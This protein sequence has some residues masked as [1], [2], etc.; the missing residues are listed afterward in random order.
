MATYH[1][2]TGAEA[3]VKR[4][5]PCVA[6]VEFDGVQVDRTLIVRGAKEDVKLRDFVVGNACVALQRFCDDRVVARNLQ[7]VGFLIDKLEKVYGPKWDC[8]VGCKMATSLD[9]RVPLHIDL[10]GTCIILTKR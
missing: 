4:S 7:M 9:D 10:D 8:T 3:P 2:S 6:R 5:V 1:D